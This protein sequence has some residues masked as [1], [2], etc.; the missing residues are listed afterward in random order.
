MIIKSEE[1]VGDIKYLT[2]ESINKLIETD[3][4]LEIIENINDYV[5][6]F[7]KID[8]ESLKEDILNPR[9]YLVKVVGKVITC[10]CKSAIFN[11]NKECRHIKL[12]KEYLKTKE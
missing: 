9:T 5:D 3:K 6:K 1:D 8:K 11:K 4:I 7:G 10:T 12:V 2:I